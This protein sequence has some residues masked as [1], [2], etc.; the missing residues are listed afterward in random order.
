[1]AQARR[2]CGSFQ[3]ADADV[4]DERQARFADEFRQQLRIRPAGHVTASRLHQ[5]HLRPRRQQRWQSFQRQADMIHH[6][7]LVARG[8]D[9]F[10][11]E[12]DDQFA[13]AESFAKLVSQAAGLN[14]SF[15]R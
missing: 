14:Y 7:E 15:S 4:R 2:G 5:R 9:D 10:R 6:A 1:M 11:S 3:S 8:D 12:A 13:R